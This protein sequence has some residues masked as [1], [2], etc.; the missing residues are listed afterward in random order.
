MVAL[1]DPL[2]R[3]AVT[4]LGGTVLTFLDRLASDRL[5]QPNLNAALQMSGTVPSDSPEI[6][7]LH[8][9]NFPFLAE[10]VRQLY[11]FRRENDT[12][13]PGTSCDAHGYY[14]LRAATLILQITDESGSGDARSRFSAWDPWQ[15]L[16]YR[17]IYRLV[18]AVETL[19]PQQGHT[20]STT[21][22]MDQVVID[23]LTNMHDA[24]DASDPNAA[25]KYGF[26]DWGWSAFYGDCTD[27][28]I[29]TCAT[30]ADGWHIEPGTSVGQALQDICA[31]GYMDIVLTP[32]YDPV[33]RPGILCEL[34]IF[35]QNSDPDSGAGSRNYAAQFAWDAPGRSLVGF[36]DLFDGTERAN[37]VQFRNGTAGPLVTLQRDATS[38]G[39]Y[40]EYWTEQ[41]F[42]GQTQAVAVEAIAAEQLVLRKDYKQT[43]TVN[44]APERSPEPWVDYMVGDRVPIFIG[45]AQRGGYVLGDNPTRGAL[46]PGFTGAVPV[47]DPAT[48]VW[49]RVY[50]IPVSID[51]NGVETVSELLVGPIGPPVT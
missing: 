35:A 33:N 31:A 45:K 34:S 38:V 8:T 13:V 32:I 29:Q 5:V 46:P 37:E 43:L 14:T 18:D 2:W 10:G 9:D 3:W 6:N 1:V 39:V 48:F 30:S 23:I 20:Y 44:P 51:D 17:P 42:P 15:Y 19:L 26:I 24:A 40:G 47:P 50:G 25:V 41:S 16:L 36:T 28:Q 4:D 49:Q 27:S 7:I 11:G 22:T 12:I 21:W